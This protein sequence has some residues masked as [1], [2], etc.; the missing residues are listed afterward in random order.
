[1]KLDGEVTD[2][3]REESKLDVWPYKECRDA[4]V[5]KKFVPYTLACYEASRE[6]STLRKYQIFIH[7]DK[8]SW[9]I[10]VKR[11]VYS[12]VKVVMFFQLPAKLMNII[13]RLRAFYD[14][15]GGNSGLSPDTKQ[16]IVSA[17][18]PKDSST[19]LINVNNDKLSI[20]YN[21]EFVDMLLVRTRVHK[22][23]N[24]WHYRSVYS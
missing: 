8:V 22:F 20:Y 13:R 24:D 23:L 15:M 19:A 10:I 11:F 17:T 1:M 9:F 7:M 5:G 6:M 3:Q 2:K 12:S 18:F 16:F 14:V 21:Q 4:S